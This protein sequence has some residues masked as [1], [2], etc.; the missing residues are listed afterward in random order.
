MSRKLEIELE[1]RIARA[2]V[3]GLL[4]AGYY[5]SVNDDDRGNGDEVLTNSRSISKIMSALQS[6]DGDLLLVRKSKA[7]DT[8]HDGWVSLIWGNVA[9]CIHDYTTNL[10]DALREANELARQYQD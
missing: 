1:T 8:G 10:E 5:I 4:K 7:H 6:T 9:D 3:K 2:A